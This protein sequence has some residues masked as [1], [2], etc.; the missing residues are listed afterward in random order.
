MGGVVGAVDVLAG[1]G[2]DVVE[3][4]S[5]FPDCGI[6]WAYLCGA[7]DYAHLVEHPLV[8]GNEDQLERSYWKGIRAASGLSYEQCGEF[9][10]MRAALNALLADLFSRFDALVTPTLPSEAFG[11]S[12]PFPTEI[13]GQ[14]LAVPIHVVAFSYPFNFSGHPAA[15]VR[16]GFTDTGLPAGLQIVAERHRDELVLQL[17]RAYERERPMDAWPERWSS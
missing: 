5:V 17:A 16:A 13:A 11:A 8:K 9:M 4:D 12:G 10:R 6:P 14:A 15:T 7:E 3:I 1:L 2:H